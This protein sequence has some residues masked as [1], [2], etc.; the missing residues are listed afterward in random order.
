M[1]RAKQNVATEAFKP[2]ISFEQIAYEK[3][4]FKLSEPLVANLKAYAAYVQASTGQQPTLD[5]VVSKGMQRLFDADKG[6]RNWLHQQNGSHHA[7][8]KELPANA[9]E[10]DESF[11]N[12]LGQRSS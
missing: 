10:S 1:P 9:G 6:F 5:E 12:A 3:V 7:A 11:G 4:S 2:L 8:V